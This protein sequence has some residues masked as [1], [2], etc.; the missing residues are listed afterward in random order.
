KIHIFLMIS[1][2]VVHYKHSF[3]AFN[4]LLGIVFFSIVFN[5]AV[6]GRL[7]SCCMFSRVRKVGITRGM[8]IV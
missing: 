5:L 8:E 2:K 7:P 4:M 3:V 6:R 1:H